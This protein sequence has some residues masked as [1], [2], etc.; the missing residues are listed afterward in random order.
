[1]KKYFGLIGL[2]VLLL[3]S[4]QTLTKTARTANVE[5]ELHSVAV[6]DL[7]VADKR[8]VYTM[9]PSKDICRGGIR[10]VKQAAESEALSKNG[11][12]DV[13][14]D[15][16]YVVT[17]KRTLFGSKITSITVTGRPAYYKNF[18]TLHDSVW[19]N[20]AF[21]G[22]SYEYGISK[23]SDSLNCKK[24][25]KSTQ[26]VAT[27]YLNSGLKIGGLDGGDGW[28]TSHDSLW[29]NYSDSLNCKNDVA[30]AQTVATGYS[31]SGWKFDGAISLLGGDDGYA[32]S[33]LINGG[34]LFSGHSLLGVGTGLIYDI[35]DGDEITII[36]LYMRYRVNFFNSE[37]T[38]FIDV[39]GGV[40][41]P[42]NAT[43]IGDYGDLERGGFFNGSIGYKFG[44]IDLAFSVL[45][46]AFDIDLDYFGFI[47]VR[48]Y[49]RTNYGVS[50]GFHF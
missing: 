28:V 7:D 34:Y 12:A 39:K 50:L 32:T 20:P 8:I 37:N 13:L 23:Y 35:S 36:P 2:I 29:S 17:K 49:E 18:R 47:G 22:V 45:Y 4:C 25:T 24:N 42:K 9:T 6:A 44:N 16:E 15:P 5:A 48:K 46:Y 11:N 14:L 3:S 27:G 1:M 31:N 19:S 21:R 10:N 38:P 41:F 30:P 26:T 33:A 40:I 43:N